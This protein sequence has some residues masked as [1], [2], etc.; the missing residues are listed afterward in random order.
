MNAAAMT[1]IQ[2]PADL[3]M[4]VYHDLLLQFCL[5]YEDWC[6]WQHV[7]TWVYQ[8]HSYKLFVD[9]FFECIHSRIPT[10]VLM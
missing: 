10:V 1:M 5:L 9:V 8:Q 6:A 3:K 2:Y 7:Q 4:R